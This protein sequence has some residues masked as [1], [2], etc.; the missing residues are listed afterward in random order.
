MSQ[1]DQ[2][3]ELEQ[4]PVPQD[5]EEQYEAH[6]SDEDS[7]PEQEPDDGDEQAEPAQ[8]NHQISDEDSQDDSDQEPLGGEQQQFEESQDFNAYSPV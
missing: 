7:V 2:Q 1:G 5:N 6:I 4:E 8:E 3:S